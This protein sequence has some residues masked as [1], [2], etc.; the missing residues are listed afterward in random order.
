MKRLYLWRET[1]EPL[2]LLLGDGGWNHPVS[3]TSLPDHMSLGETPS[4]YTLL[5]NFFGKIMCTT[6]GHHGG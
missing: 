4:G 6:Q 1:V 2:L 3:L 5:H